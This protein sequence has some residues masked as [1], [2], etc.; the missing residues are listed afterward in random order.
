MNE[1]IDILKKVG[2]I[3]DN[4]HFVG[5]SGLHF[6]T[7]INK[8]FLYPHTKETSDMCKLFAEKYKDANIDIVVGPALGGIILSQWTANHL[9][10]NYGKEV[11]G[12]Y[13]EKS[14]DGGQIFTRGY[15]KYIKDKRVLVVEDII[16]TGGSI[17]KTIQAVKEAGGN[18]VGACA[19][20]NKNKDLDKNIFS[21]P[22]NALA[23]LFIETYAV[24]VCPLCKKGISININV[25]HG[26]KYL[27]SLK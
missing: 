18:I 6:D 24:D 2:A 16:T 8:D 9:S 26:K 21:V 14:A 27:E 11:L 17:L 15:E 22:F 5:A 4:G 20:V 3:L 7:Y 19:M 12:I 25:G 1:V 10:E 13:T 23:E